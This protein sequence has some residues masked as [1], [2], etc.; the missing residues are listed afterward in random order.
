VIDF[1]DLQWWPVFNLA[2]SVVVVG[3][4]VILWLGN[5]RAADPA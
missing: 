2:D 5:L 1:V 3:A 4:V